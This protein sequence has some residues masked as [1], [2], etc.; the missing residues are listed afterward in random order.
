V[1][2]KCGSD[3]ACKLELILRFATTGPNSS[4]EG[5]VELEPTLEVLI[6]YPITNR[7]PDGA[8]LEAALERRA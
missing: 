8:V 3:V 7:V 1:P 2:N 4:F 6:A 5:P